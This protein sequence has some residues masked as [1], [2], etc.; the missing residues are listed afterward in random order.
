MLKYLLIL[1]GIGMLSL[2]G[3]YTAPTYNDVNFTLCS[4]YTPPLY[5]DV[6]FTLGLDDSCGEVDINYSSNVGSLRFLNCSPDWTFYP[7]SPSGQTV[8]ISAI[9]AT[10]NGTLAGEF[11]IKY[12]GSINAGWTLFSCNDSSADPNADEDC[13]TMSDS[14]QMIWDSVD[15]DETK[16]I[17]LYGN[18]SF[19]SANPGVTTDIQAV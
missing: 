14:F 17:W 7:T 16:R 12:I 3:S 10:N 19:I 1:V 9:N 11:Q 8:T 5:N 13:I 6:N 4:G 15:V 18:C 2:V